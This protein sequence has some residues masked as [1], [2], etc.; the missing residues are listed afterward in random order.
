[1]GADSVLKTQDEN[2]PINDNTNFHSNTNVSHSD[3]GVKK[4]NFNSSSNTNIGKVETDNLTTTEG[5]MDEYLEE[6][7]IDDEDEE[8]EPL[9]EDTSNGIATV[10]LTKTSKTSHEASESSDHSDANFNKRRTDEESEPSDCGKKSTS[11]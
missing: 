2:V 11:R 9:K 7:E 1:M 3:S 10:D 5:D 6:G 4:A 8:E